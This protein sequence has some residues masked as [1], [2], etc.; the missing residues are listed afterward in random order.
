MARPFSAAAFILVVFGA[1]VCGAVYKGGRTVNHQYR[2]DKF[3]TPSEGIWTYFSSWNDNS[4]CRV[5][6]I[7]NIS[8][9]T[10]S[11]ETRYNI[12]DRRDVRTSIAEL[13]NVWHREGPLNVMSMRDESQGRV[14][15]EFVFASTNYTCAVLQVERF[16]GWPPVTFE[17]LVKE[18][19][20]DD[21]PSADCVKEYNENVDARRTRQENRTV[22]YQECPRR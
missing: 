10:V 21:G 1:T 6:I 13:S 18:S 15:K 8:G 9:K 16:R 14:Y 5:D 17:L 19:H 12:S 4:T 22:Y 11:L 7:K 2:F 3:L 20:L